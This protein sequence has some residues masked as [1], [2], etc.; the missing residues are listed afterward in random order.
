MFWPALPV[1]ATVGCD[2]LAVWL[3]VAAPLVVAV[4]L[5]AELLVAVVV[6]AGALG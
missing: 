3:A 1:A 6:C 5:A 4:A 2:G